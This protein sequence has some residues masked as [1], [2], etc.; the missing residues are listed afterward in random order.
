MKI[1][2]LN[3][4][5]GR[6]GKEKL[7]RFFAERGKDIDAFCLQEVWSAPYEQLEGLAAGG[8]AINH[9]HVLA[10][11]KQE[12]GT[13][14][15]E[16][17]SFFH[18]H[19]LD[20]YGLLTLVRK[21]IP[22]TQEGEVFVHKF[23]GYTPQGDVGHH[24]R[25]VQFVRM[26]NNDKPLWLLNFHGLWNG[27]GKTDSDDRILQSQKCIDFIKTLDGDVVFCGDFNLL[28]D[29]LSIKMLED[30]GLRNLVKEY[31]VTSTRTSL[32][33]KQ[34]KFAD[35]IFVSQGVKVKDFQVLK[36]EVSD[37]TPLLVEIG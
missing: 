28:P 15:P 32:Y 16:H 24:A 29:T 8:L 19:Y 36:D 13:L 10:Y 17:T 6:A 37:H 1:L 20:N 14:L 30:A 34:E 26:L 35:Y 11:G 12:I 2:T 22:L 27:K 9:D 23:K 33:T 7:L 25:N 4:W 21:D 18:P 3:T 31:G 5:G